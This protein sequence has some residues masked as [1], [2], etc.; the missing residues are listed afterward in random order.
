MFEILL[1]AIRSGASIIEVPMVLKSQN[2]K[3]KS[4]MKILKT[5][6]QYVK[7][8]LKIGLSG[9]PVRCIRD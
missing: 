5:M 7:Y 3:D 2:R 1:K 9:L 8:V 4:K 6:G